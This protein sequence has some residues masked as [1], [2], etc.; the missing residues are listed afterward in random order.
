MSLRN[1][2]HS[3]NQPR[4]FVFASEWKFDFHDVVIVVYFFVVKCFGVQ[5]DISKLDIF[6]YRYPNASVGKQIR[7][8]VSVKKGR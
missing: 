5:T 3:R 2:V 6:V 7:A 4:C 1:E 8:V